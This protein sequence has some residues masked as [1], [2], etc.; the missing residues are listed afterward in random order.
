MQVVPKITEVEH[1]PINFQKTLVNLKT[2]VEYLN[3]QVITSLQV[4]NKNSDHEYFVNSMPDHYQFISTS[5][6]HLPSSS[7]CHLSVM[8]G[9]HGVSVI[10]SLPHLY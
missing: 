8:T 3:L 1:L 6:L 5:F 7:S 10:A 2:V 4:L 9:F